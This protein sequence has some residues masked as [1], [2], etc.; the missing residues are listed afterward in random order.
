MAK[1]VSIHYY[2]H[3]AIQVVLSVTECE[4]F[5]IRI[6][7]KIHIGFLIIFS[8]VPPPLSPR[9]SPAALRFKNNP[10]VLILVPVVLRL[11]PVDLRSRL[12][13]FLFVASPMRGSSF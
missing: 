10:V 7:L 12:R 8:P 9:S 2:F 4:V 1:G 6:V 11:S 3:Y 5:P 13:L